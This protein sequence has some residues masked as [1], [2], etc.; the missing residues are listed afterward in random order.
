[1]SKDKKN[2]CRSMLTMESVT[3][4]VPVGM[5]KYLLTMNPEMELTRNINSRMERYDVKYFF[6]RDAIYHPPTYFDN[7]YED[8]W[9]TDPLSI[10]MIRDI[11]KSDVLGVHLIESPVLGPISPKD[12]SGGVKTLMLMAFADQDKVFNASA[13]GDNCAKWILK[14]GQGKDLTINLNHI[15]NFGEDSFEAKILNTGEVVHDMLDFIKIAGQY[16]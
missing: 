15:M 8:E 1:M 3:I 11:D 2:G 14:I 13:C 6:R 5:S 4:K 9:I 16:V 10:E 7:V 12:L